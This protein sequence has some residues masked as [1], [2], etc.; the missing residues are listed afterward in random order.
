MS[1]IYNK[2]HSLKKLIQRIILGRS[3]KM[4][5]DDIALIY[6]MMPCMERVIDA[7][8]G[9]TGHFGIYK[10]SHPVYTHVITLAVMKL[11]YACANSFDTA[12]VELYIGRGDDGHIKWHLR[13]YCYEPSVE[14]KRNFSLEYH[15]TDAFENWWDSVLYVFQ[16]QVRSVKFATAIKQE[17]LQKVICSQYSDATIATI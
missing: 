2:Y 14:F 4:N 6:S 9:L 13:N 11:N 7:R 12:G 15:L 17:L 5:Q 3:S 8:F 1:R 10:N 16:S